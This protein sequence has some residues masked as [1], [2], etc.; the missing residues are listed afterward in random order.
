MTLFQNCNFIYHTGTLYITTVTLFVIINILQC[1]FVF[2]IMPLYLTLVTSL[3]LWLWLFN[4]T[5]YDYFPI[6]TISCKWGFISHNHAFLFHNCNYF[7]YY[8]YISWLW[9]I[10]Y[11]CSF[12]SHISHNYD[13][14]FHSCNYFTIV[15]LFQVMTISYNCNFISHNYEFLFYNFN[16]IV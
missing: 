14:L 12:I 11:N 6:V 8:N 3:F 15:T 16:F 10:S 13:F 1:E 5:D 2:Y 9:F 4:F 7:S